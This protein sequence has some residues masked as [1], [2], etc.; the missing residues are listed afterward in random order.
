MGCTDWF[1]PV[2]RTNG[3]LQAALQRARGETHP[4]YIEVRLEPS[5]ITPMS[6]RVFERV[7]QISEPSSEAWRPVA[8]K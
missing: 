5:M 3:E 4:T 6:G 1:T 7:Y 8:V 2:V